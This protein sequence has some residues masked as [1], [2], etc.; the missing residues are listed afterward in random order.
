MVQLVRM[1]KFHISLFRLKCTDILVFQ[2]MGLGDK[3]V[4]RLY[5][6][7]FVLLQGQEDNNLM[8]SRSRNI[9]LAKV[10]GYL[11]SMGDSV[12]DNALDLL[13]SMEQYQKV[14]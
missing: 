4:I 11:H 9:D 10:K 5:K 13:Q 6:V 7:K 2:F 8:R 1:E 12:P 14:Y 3:T